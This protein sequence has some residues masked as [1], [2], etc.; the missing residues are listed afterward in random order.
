M[1]DLDHFRKPPN[2]FWLFAPFVAAIVL[3]VAWSG[4]WLA[5]RAST[6]SRIDAT[7]A[8]LR[9]EGWTV[10]W[11]RRVIAG[12]PFRIEVSLDDVHIAEPSGWGAAAP[13]LEAVANAYDL[14]HWV[15]AL[16]QG[17]VLT[18]PGAGA[19]GVQAQL[20]RA[21]VIGDGGPPPRILLEAAKLAFTPQ[22]GAKALPIASAGHLQFDVRPGGA[23][24][25]QVYSR[26]DGAT[27]QP[28]GALAVM[29]GARP[30]T[31]EIKAWAAKI[32]A[33]HGR[34]W[35]SAVRAWTAAGGEISLYEGQITAT[36]GP[37]V[38]ANQGTLNVSDDGRLSGTL[39]ST[40]NGAAPLL[41]NL[42]AARVIDANAADLAA[43]VVEARTAGA[44]TAK[45][46]IG[47]QAGVTTLG[48]VAI[49]PAPRVF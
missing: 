6:A 11:S 42:G 2:P 23:G 44:P 28:G 43:S 22:P 12:Y 18:R 15:F 31:I 8:R 24:Q 37:S 20:L 13:R 4:A 48:P 47:F 29:V 14:G 38:V 26:I 46:D 34:D 25:A 10:D 49:A 41:R 33:L 30:L 35:P 1:P 32:A 3:V 9:A 36:Q 39:P 21:S 40:L 27:A 17:L 45:V 5:F 19:V 7:T 16:T